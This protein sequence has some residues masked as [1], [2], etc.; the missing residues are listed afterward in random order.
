MPKKKQPTK[1]AKH[2][3]AEK[4]QKKD[5]KKISEENFAGWQ[6]AKAD[7]KNLEKQ[8]EKRQLE[9]RQSVRSEIVQDLLPI[10]DN[11]NA[12]FDGLKPEDQNSEWVKGFD[13]IK[14]QIEKYLE[15]QGIE[16]I[17]SVGETFDPNLH[18]A[19]E[20]VTGPKDEVISEVRR[21]Y[22][23]GDKILRPSHVTV[24]NGN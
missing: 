18:H 10:L 19:V 12:A 1:S 17:Q 9:M 23:L 8:V 7:F 3:I 15:E 6:R 14:Q 21:G 24:G 16:K 11:F 22:R 5:Y 2:K 13:F 20:Q 4:I